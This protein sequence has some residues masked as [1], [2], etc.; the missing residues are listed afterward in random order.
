MNKKILTKAISI[1]MGLTMATSFVACGGGGKKGGII[2]D[3]KT[4]NVRVLKAGYGDA[5]IY[6]LKDK[7]EKVYESE[8]YK[9]NILNPSS[10]MRGSVAMTELMQGYD[11]IKVDLYLSGDLQVEHLGANG[12]YGVLAE[13]LGELVWN[14]KA[15]GY[16]GVEE[17]ATIISKVAPANLTVCRDSNGVLYSMPMMASSA[18]LV[19][20]IKKLAKYGLELPRTTNELLDCFRKIYLGHNGIANSEESKMFPIT[21]VPG[22][23]NGYTQKWVVNMVAQYD[24]DEFT[25][26]M[27]MQTTDESGNVTK[28]TEDGYKV[29]NYKGIEE[30]LTV[31]YEV[32][33]TNI[34]SY[35]TAQQTLDQAQAQIMKENGGAVFM[36]NGEWMLNE[37]KLNYKNQLND[38]EF[39]NTPVLSAV[40]TRLFGSGTDYNLSD[41]KCEEILCCIID[42]ADAGKSVDEIVTAVKTDCNV[43]IKKEDAE[44][45]AIARGTYC[46]RSLE[47][48][49]VVIPKGT[50]KKDI[51]AK[52][53]RMLASYDCAATIAK[54]ANSAS[55]YGLNADVTNPYKFVQQS[56]A[57]RMHKYANVY[58]D[59][60]QGY[61]K[62]LQ[63]GSFMALISH[64]ATE[65]VGQDISVYDGEGHL[66]AGRDYSL[67][68]T[69]AQTMQ[70]TDYAKAQD[71]WST[72]KQKD[73]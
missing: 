13:D 51:S 8:G 73:K 19:V 63:A 52:F 44:E 31:A 43:D 1:V 60:V 20:N 41:E 18:G 70:A 27:T 40:G 25:E 2:D 12:D 17:D 38:I 5:W 39:I 26:L 59:T 24:F 48:V 29:F 67:Y 4:I 7:F 34:A 46:D 72:W 35:G 11:K 3:E 30:M 49:G 21:Y 61:R 14:Q 56:I 23:T 71:M 50:P 22:V 62:R 33:D 54:Q 6:E 66:A 47:G 53:L 45:A 28:M 42:A 64:V 68:R 32:F 15:I 55:A 65:I 58:L 37:V 9:V 16:D 36:A 10:D 57:V 69:S